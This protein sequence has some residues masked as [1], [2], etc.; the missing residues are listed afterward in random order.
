MRTTTG[1]TKKRKTLTIR[2]IPSDEVIDK[3]HDEQNVHTEAGGQS[4]SQADITEEKKE[5]EYKPVESQE[6]EENQN[7]FD[8]LQSIE[9]G[10]KNIN[11]LKN[12]AELAKDNFINY[13]NATNF[14]NKL[15]NLF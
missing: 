15:I 9:Y 4:N 10:L 6:I 3:E 14:V 11:T 2:E 12:K 1:K 8:L 5:N 7:K 13:H